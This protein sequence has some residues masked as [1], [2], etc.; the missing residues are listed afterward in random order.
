MR[1]LIDIGNTRIKWATFADGAFLETGEA[2]HRDQVLDDALLF[3]DQVLGRINDKPEQVLAANVAGEKIGNAVH[4][5]VRARWGLPVDFAA[6]QPAAGDVFNGY[7]DYRQMGVD[8]WL[9]IL[10][11]RHRYRQALCV[12]D[13]GTAV[14]ADQVD[15]SGKHLGGVIVPGL[16]LMRRSLVSDTGDIATDLES[17]PAPERLIFGRSTA[18]AIDGGVLSAICGLIEDCMAGLSSRYGD[19]VLVVTGGDA[20]RIIPQLRVDA[21]HRPL[22]VLEGLAIYVPG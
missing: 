22:L 10:G 9:A 4:D 21:D 16:D 18:D 20:E 6:T 17:E 15:D 2:V 5:A 8:R 1:L 19:S 13:A 14:T 7:D 3:V 11:A 12:V